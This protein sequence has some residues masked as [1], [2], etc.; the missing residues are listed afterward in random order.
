MLLTTAFH[1]QHESETNRISTLENINANFV[2]NG[3]NPETSMDTTLAQSD[4]T[5]LDLHTVLATVKALPA[6]KRN[7]VLKL[8]PAEVLA[9]IVTQL[10]DDIGKSL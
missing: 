5:D 6:E 8:L 10:S 3:K 9:G 4:D 1:Y 2:E 7:E